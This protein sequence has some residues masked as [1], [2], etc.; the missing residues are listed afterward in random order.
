MCLKTLQLK[1]IYNVLK[2]EKW[3]KKGFTIFYYKNNN[4]FSNNN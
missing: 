4:S 3:I 2:N 1:V